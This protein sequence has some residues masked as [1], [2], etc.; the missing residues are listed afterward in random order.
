MINISKKHY[1]VYTHM[2]QYTNYYD[3]HVTNY[4]VLFKEKNKINKINIMKKLK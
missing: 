4:Y 2:L 3:I 1:L